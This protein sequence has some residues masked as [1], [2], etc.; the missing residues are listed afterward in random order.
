MDNNLK[1]NSLPIVSFLAV[2]AASIVL[3]V[4]VPASCIAVTLTGVIAML[5]SDYG[6]DLQ[7]V[8]AR[9]DVIA[10]EFAGR[11]PAELNRAA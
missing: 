2:L 10:V 8:R 11:S 1:T 4:S 7:P 6:R 3:P 9:A 5:A